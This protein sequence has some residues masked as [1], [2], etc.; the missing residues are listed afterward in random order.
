MVVKVYTDHEVKNVMQE[1]EAA[2]KHI[3]RWHSSLSKGKKEVKI[4]KF[5]IS[6]KN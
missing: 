4:Y 6:T 1:I 5:E 3:S 2:S